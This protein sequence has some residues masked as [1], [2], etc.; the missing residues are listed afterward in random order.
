MGLAGAVCVCAV[1]GVEFLVGTA[2]D[3]EPSSLLISMML[4]SV[5]AMIGSNALARP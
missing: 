4:G 2:L 5:V 1:L 3:L